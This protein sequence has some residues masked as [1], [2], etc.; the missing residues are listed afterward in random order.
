MLDS[1]VG[2]I[3]N[4]TGYIGALKELESS[5]NNLIGTSADYIESLN[6]MSVAFGDNAQAA[7][8]WTVSLANAYGLDEATLVKTMGLFRQIGNSLEFG[9]ENA[10]KFAKTLTQMQLDIS[11]LY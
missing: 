10:D 11:S 7:K 8:D 4:I 1:V 9:A 5:L 6:L 3:T 2:K